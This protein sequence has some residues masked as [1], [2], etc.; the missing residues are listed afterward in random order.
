VGIDSLPDNPQR[1][2][3]PGIDVS[4]I[5][6]DLLNQLSAVIGPIVFPTWNSRSLRPLVVHEHGSGF[7]V[8]PHQDWD[9]PK[10]PWAQNKLELWV[11]LGPPP[12]NSEVGGSFRVWDTAFDEASYKKH[13]RGSGPELLDTAVGKHKEH[14]FCG[15]GGLVVLNTALIHAMSPLAED[16]VRMMATGFLSVDRTTVSLWS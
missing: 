4:F 8:R 14:F 12:T 7:V 15:V 10:Y 2:F 1:Y 16:T 5:L 11:N 3:D 9:L 6:L 13:Q